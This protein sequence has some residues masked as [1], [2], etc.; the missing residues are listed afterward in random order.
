MFDLGS[1]T[2]SM[3]RLVTGV[4]DDQLGAPT[5]CND[6]T[7]TQLLAHIHQFTAVFTTNARKQTARPP[8]T[9]V[10][11]WRTSMPHD[12][13]EL[14]EAWRQPSAWEGRTSAGGVDMDA[15]TNALVAV[16][17]LTVHGWDLA[18]ATG[19]IF[20]PAD[21]ELSRVDEFVTM[22]GGAENGPYGPAVP[23]PPDADR[24][25]TVI[26]RTGRDPGWTR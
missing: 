2:A 17:E 9:L 12:L 23:V 7:V 1:A 4:R 19:Q 14:A 18:R 24:V 11:D 22:F 5:P 6:W 25:Q 3:S 26:A 16:E 20:S 10:D 15:A 13:G 8:T 21:D